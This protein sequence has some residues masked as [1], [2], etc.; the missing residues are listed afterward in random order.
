M[1]IALVVIP[2]LIV[3]GAA[4]L[5]W[6]MAARQRAEAAYHAGLTQSI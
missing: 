4:V 5:V 2:L 1:R 6:R 3:V